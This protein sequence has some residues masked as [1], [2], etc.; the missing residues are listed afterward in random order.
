M[1]SAS[2][3]AG[4]L[5]ACLL[6]T[7][8]VPAQEPVPIGERTTAGGVTSSTPGPKV[9][10]SVEEKTLVDDVSLQTWLAAK[11]T[12][13]LVVVLPRS[14]GTSLF[15]FR[16]QPAGQPQTYAVFHAAEAL[17]ADA[18]EVRLAL[19]KSRSFLGIHLL[20][21]SSYLLVYADER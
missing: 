16:N 7:V 1:R 17:S 13:R 20:G 10:L 15:V 5:A 18:L 3:A 8:G 9:V 12:E 19:Q 21:P 6:F 4:V 11:T 14:A 2:L